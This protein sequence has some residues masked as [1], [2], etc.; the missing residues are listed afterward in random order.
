MALF[1]RK[2]RFLTFLLP[3]LLALI[4]F[5]FTS[6]KMRRAPW[7]KE[8]VWNILAPPQRLVTG[9]TD[10]VSGMWQRYIALIGVEGER[11]ELAKRVNVLEGELA[12]TDEVEKE[13]E[14]LRSL[15]AYH[16]SFP[17][18]TI[19]ATVIA[20]DP[21]AEFKSITINRGAKDGI[22][23]LMPVVGPKGLVGKVGTVGRGHARI[24]LL[25]DPNSAIDAMVQRSRARGMVVGAAWRA[26]LESGYYIARLEYLRR[27]SDI[28]DGDVVV[29][30]GFDQVF[31]P[32]IPIGKVSDVATSRYGVFTKADVVPFE[33]MSELQ[34]VL[35][36]LSPTRSDVVSQGEEG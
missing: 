12:K 30:S 4:F 10:G 2:S 15:L 33:D 13:N 11:A 19:V 26:E 27:V 31:P 35:V 16:D 20:N 24:L 36:I 25:T 8:A 29:T 5:S 6:M 17:H 28:R 3:L 32:G 23:P 1:V 18:R 7:Y 21:R 22:K 14:R 34:Q 9:M